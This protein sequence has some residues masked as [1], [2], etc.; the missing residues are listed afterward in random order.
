M[1]VGVPL[2]VTSRRGGK[3]SAWVFTILLVSLYYLIS[4]F[5]VA[6]GQQNRIPAFFRVWSAN[7]IF[8]TAGVCLL[9][10]MTSG[11][12]LL[13]A[14]A[15]WTSRSPNPSFAGAPLGGLR[16]AFQSRPQ[17]GKARNV[18]PQDRKSTR[19]NSSHLGI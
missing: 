17:R 10:Q 12:R 19:L 3:S 11:G 15:T 18:F 6:L 2:G 14:I 16:S 4:T 5:G 1:L 7:L 9:W 8:A 13:N